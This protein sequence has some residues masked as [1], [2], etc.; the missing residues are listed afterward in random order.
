MR[1]QYRNNFTVDGWIAARLRVALTLAMLCVATTRLFGQNTLPPPVLSLDAPTNVAC[2]Q[3]AHKE[4]DARPEVRSVV[5]S[6][7]IPKQAKIVSILK[8]KLP[9]SSDPMP[10]KDAPEWFQ[11]LMQRVVRENVPDKFVREKDWDKTDRR[12]DGVHLKRRG[13]LD[14]STKRKWKEVNHGTWKRYENTQIDP[15][16]NLTMR[17]ENVRDAGAG[18]IGF[19]IRL[20]SK[21][22]AFGRF[23]KWTKGVQIYNVS[24]D[25]DA[26]VELRMECSVG[27][28]LD[29]RKFPPDVILT[30]T[31]TRADLVVTDFELQKVSKLRGPM[32]RELS[33]SVHRVLLDRI[34]KKRKDLPAKINRQIE[35]NQDKMRLSLS[36][37]AT[38]KWNALAESDFAKASSSSKVIAAD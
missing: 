13:L 16:E 8:R 20:T 6:T 24:V 31:A 11:A 7:Q 10:V 29:I 22:H 23:A 33:G 4:T 3:P 15:E 37:F 27:T 36:D 17:I 14:W 26:G 21:L 28:K 32:V 12:W 18:H 34:E 5:H 25:V 35:K 2:P 9:P 1:K 30:P 38:S 19:D